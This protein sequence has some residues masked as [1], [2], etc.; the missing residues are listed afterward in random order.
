MIPAE[1]VIGII[2]STCKAFETET[3]SEKTRM[4]VMPAIDQEIL[5]GFFDGASEGAP[6]IC[7]VGAVLDINKHHYMHIR[8]SPGRDSKFKQQS[9]VYST[10]DTNICCKFHEYEEASDLWR[11]KTGG[12]WGL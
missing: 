6:Q 3:K 2:D 10:L 5:W 4:L 1:V 9:G 8:Y 12:G 11:F 7:G